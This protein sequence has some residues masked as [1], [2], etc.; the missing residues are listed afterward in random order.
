[1]KNLVI[2]ILGGIVC[3]VAAVVAAD[4]P[5]KKLEPAPAADATASIGQLIGQ[6]GSSNFFLREQWAG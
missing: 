1:M 4:A 2:A 5:A 3:L 6:L